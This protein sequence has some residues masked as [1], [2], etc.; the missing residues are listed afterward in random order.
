MMALTATATP[1]V[2]KDI[3][4]QLNMT[5]PQVYVLHPGPGLRLFLRHEFCLSIAKFKGLKSSI[6]LYFQVYHEFQ[7][8]Q[9]QV[10]CAAQKT[11]KGGRGLHQLDQEAL[12]T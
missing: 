8:N 6:R 7:Q 3:L 4:H 1:R 12:P 2:Q 11:Q 9:P 10:R 5:R